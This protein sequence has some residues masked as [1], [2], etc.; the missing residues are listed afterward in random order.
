MAD[1]PLATVADLADRLGR[2]LTPEEEARAPSLLSTASSAVRA[3]TR[4]HLT[5]VA[6]DVA[7]LVPHGQTLTL[8]QRPVT[9]VTLVEVSGD[10]VTYD[11]VTDYRARRD[12][13]HR[14]TCWG[15]LARVTYSHGYDPIPDDIIDVVCAMAFR[16]LAKAP[17]SQDLASEQ[18]GEY[19]YR[20]A[21]GASSGALGLLLPE[22]RIL[23]R[24][25]RSARSVPL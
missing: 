5:A 14:S 3:Y 19:S 16:G 6:D 15:W 18:I 17:V 10:G 1:T 24:Y 9:A 4:Q 11:E 13:L 22:R 23:D 20:L 2:A 12:T 8:P 7:T 25:R 21:D